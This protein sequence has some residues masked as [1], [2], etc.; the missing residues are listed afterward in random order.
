MHAHGSAVTG[1][2]DVLVHA[3]IVHATAAPIPQASTAPAKDAVMTDRR[4][5]SGAS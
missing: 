4:Q 1:S 2:H 5:S 3:K